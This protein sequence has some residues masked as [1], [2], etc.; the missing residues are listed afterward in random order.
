MP[1]ELEVPVFSEETGQFIA[2]VRVADT[3]YQLRLL[4]LKKL[5]FGSTSAS[6]EFKF[7]CNGKELW[8]HG[9]SLEE[10]GHGFAVKGY[11]EVKATSVTVNF[12]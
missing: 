11:I 10:Y 4:L 3:L 7:Y 1:L 6:P 12:Y 2:N 8:P 5:N 9:K